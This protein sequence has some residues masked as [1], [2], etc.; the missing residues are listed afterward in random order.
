[1]TR[2]AAQLR[3]RLREPQQQRAI[4]TRASILRAATGEF[5]ARGLHGAR[6]AAIARHA[7]VNKQRLY[8][9]FGSKN[10]LFAEVLRTCFADMSV[11]EASLRDLGETDIPALP[12]KILAAYMRVHER[13][14]H[15][16][17]LLAWE[18]LSGAPHAAALRGLQDATFAHLRTLYARGQQLGVY[19][20]R[21][22]FAT[23]IFSLIALSYFYYAN[24][25]TMSQSL[26]LDLADTA[27]RD[28]F[29]SE[30]VLL[31]GKSGQ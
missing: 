2:A 9:Y 7:G 29:I 22:S 25:L 4:R 12:A 20:S 11:Q 8:A 16:W 23:F 24:R 10:G 27:V 18:N 31:I 14:P 1:M 26:N 15:F 21:V 3:D 30:A 17:R 19:E 13:F 5:S 6:I 28:R